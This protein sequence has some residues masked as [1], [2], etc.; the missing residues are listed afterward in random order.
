MSKISCN[1]SFPMIL[2]FSVALTILHQVHGQEICHAPIPGNGSCN[3]GSC[4]SHCAQF[5][6]GSVGTC[7]QTFTNR[8]TCQCSW[9]CS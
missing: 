5:F 2:I 9:R 4:S 3:A 1:I 8:F 7:T 6:K